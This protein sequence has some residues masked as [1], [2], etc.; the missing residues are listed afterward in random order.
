M[1]RKEV[2]FGKIDQMSRKEVEGRL[3][4]LLGSAMAK[5]IV[6]Q[7]ELEEKEKSEGKVYDDHSASRLVDEVGIDDSP[8]DTKESNP[9]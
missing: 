5:Q 2:M 9:V 8:D 4:Q 7:K 1:D 3:E 6:R